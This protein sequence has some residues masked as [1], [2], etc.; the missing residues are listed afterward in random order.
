MIR[1]QYAL[2]LSDSRGP[3]VADGLRRVLRTVQNRNMNNGS[4]RVRDE[5]TLTKMI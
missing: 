3:R 5:L 1:L 2:R 4:D